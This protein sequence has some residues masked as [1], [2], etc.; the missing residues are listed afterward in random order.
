MEP[1]KTQ[2]MQNGAMHIQILQQNSAQKGAKR[3]GVKIESIEGA[4]GA[5]GANGATNGVKLRWGLAPALSVCRNL[6][7][8]S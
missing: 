5:I 7:D 2:R 4:N 8:S 1:L 6:R 3:N